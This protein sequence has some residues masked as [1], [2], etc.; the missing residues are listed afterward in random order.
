MHEAPAH[1]HFFGDR[2]RDFRLTPAEIIELERVTGAGIGGLCK[3]M[4]AGDFA[5]RQITETIRLAL[6]GGG[7]TPEDAAALV[8]TYAASRP[9]MEVYP[10]AVSIL[11]T[12]MFGRVMT[13]AAD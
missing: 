1:R 10:L 7:E 12:L 13:N 5:H 8:T 3:R 4:F 9:I 6:I 11:E 2:D